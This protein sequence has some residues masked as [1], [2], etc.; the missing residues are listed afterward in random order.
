[1]LEG[2]TGR[3]LDRE[4]HTTAEKSGK[5]KRLSNPDSDTLDGKTGEIPVTQADEL[6]MLLQ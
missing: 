2:V 4:S 6:G 1:M 5:V 3:G